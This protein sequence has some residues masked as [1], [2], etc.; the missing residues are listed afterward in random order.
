[1]L[2][3]FL[4]VLVTALDIA[5]LAPSLRSIG[6]Y[7]SVTD[8]RV[9]S[10][11]FI[12]FTLFAQIGIP[13]MSWFSDVYGRRFAYSLCI[14]L[15][16]VGLCVV[17]LSP[18][19][20]ALLIGRAI[21]G[22]GVS[23]IVPITS[24][25][26]GDLYPVDKRG[27]MLG[28]IG[29]VFGLAFIVGPIMSGILIP[30]GWQWPFRILVPLAITVWIVALFRLPIRTQVSSSSLDLGGILTLV[31]AVT[32]ITIGV[33]RLETDNLAMSIRSL[34][35]WPFIVLAVLS[36]IAFL[37]IEK[38]TRKPFIRLEIF[39]SRQIT[40]A[41]LISIGAGLSE[42]VFVFLPSF[43]FVA[44]NVSDRAA[45]IMLMPLVLALA[46]G[47]PLTGR[48]VDRIGARWIVNAGTLFVT[49]GMV[50]LSL[51]STQKA[52]YYAGIACIGFGLSALLGSSISYIL[53]NEAR[54]D[55]R[56]LVQGV[57]RLFKGF[58]RLIGGSLVGAIVASAAIEVTGYKI[59]FFVIAIVGGSLHVLSYRLRSRGE[60]MATMTV[61]V[62]KTGTQ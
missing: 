58:G 10:W 53:L 36:F 27:R 55:E 2:I 54:E 60:D 29:A 5:I 11:V 22:L 25:V 30:Y 9:L 7:F 33:S 40:I 52:L 14:G 42:A 34:S 45:S 3:L 61:Q 6:E 21:Q 26:I 18:S 59:A 57:S 8:E 31:L 43:A 38:K 23:G 32:A 51:V 35:V 50:M 49:L 20:D 47:A 15:F 48:L 1:M 44:F 56:T 24:A 39:E 12:I 17:V 62:P 37:W 16:T 28:I 46:I 13:F 19:Y 41:C 4:G